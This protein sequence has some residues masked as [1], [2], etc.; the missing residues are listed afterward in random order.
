MILLKQ[1]KSWYNIV[2]I[3]LDALFLR[4]WRYLGGCAS[5]NLIPVGVISP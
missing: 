5:I 1:N 3:F 2:Y 4:R